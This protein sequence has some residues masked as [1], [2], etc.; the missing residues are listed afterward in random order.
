AVSTEVPGPPIH[1]TVLIE[2]RLPEPDLRR[3]DDPLMRH[4]LDTGQARPYS[5]AGSRGGSYQTGGLAVTE[6]PYRLLDGN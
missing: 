4:L 1:S 6:R 2:A 3:T 5:I